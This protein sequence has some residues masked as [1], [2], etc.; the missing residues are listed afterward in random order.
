MLHQKE[1]SVAC[2]A[3]NVYVLFRFLDQE[4][5]IRNITETESITV[6]QI[7]EL[8]PHSSLYI[9]PYKQM[10]SKRYGLILYSSLDRQGSTEEAESLELALQAAGCDVMKMEWSNGREL[11][12]LIDSCLDKVSADCAL[13]VVSVMA[14]GGRGVVK[15]SAGGLI[16]V[17]DILQ[18]FT[19]RLP[20]HTPMVRCRNRNTYRRACMYA[21][22]FIIIK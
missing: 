14:H 1:I 9:I 6:E 20:V 7:E 16:S 13:L 17:N 8:S 3:C 12:S 4:L 18:Q 10:K 2:C 15:G 5:Q 22:T 19:A 21:Y 11:H